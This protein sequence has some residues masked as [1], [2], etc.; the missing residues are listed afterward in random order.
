MYVVINKQQKTFLKAYG[1]NDPSCE[2]SS[3]KLTLM[4]KSHATRVI[5]HHCSG[6]IPFTPETSKGRKIPCSFVAVLKKLATCIATCNCHFRVFFDRT[7]R[8]SFCES[9]SWSPLTPMQTMQDNEARNNWT[10]ERELH[11]SYCFSMEGSILREYW[12]HHHHVQV[13]EATL[14]H[15]ENLLN[16][17]AKL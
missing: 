15:H 4:L 14:S 10:K 1:P 6:S 8:S 2:K 7:Q 9:H 11:A 16:V 3:R 12:M 5:T 17:Q 13:K